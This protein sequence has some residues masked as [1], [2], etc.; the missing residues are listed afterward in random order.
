[1]KKLTAITLFAL[2]TFC[3]FAEQAVLWCEDGKDLQLSEKYSKTAWFNKEIAMSA[4]PDGGFTISS[5]A[6]KF[7]KFSEEYPWLCFEII[8]SELVTF[9]KYSSWGIHVGKER[10]VGNVRPAAPGIYAV[11]LGKVDGNL[12]KFYIYNLKVNFRYLKLVKVP[13]NYLQIILPEGKTELGKG[14]KLR[15]Q[16]TLAEPCED[17]SCQ[18]FFD[19]GHGPKAFNLNGTN[20]LELKADNDELTKWSTEVTID[21]N[22]V[23]K[24]NSVTVKVTT[25]GSKLKTPIWGV[26]TASFVQ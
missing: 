5:S 11:N 18:L 1:M 26:I 16:L 7:V 24:T 21:K 15:F 12:L 8:D 4:L 9:G 20:A 3:C 6:S 14:D 22:G 23:A 25:L 13:E 19:A 17:L 10:K 2:M